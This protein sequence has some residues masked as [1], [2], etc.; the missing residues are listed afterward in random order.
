[1]QPVATK[2]E[3]VDGINDYSLRI[4]QMPGLRSFGALHPDTPPEEMTRQIDFL[5]THG[6]AG[7]KLHPDYQHF[8]PHEDRLESMYSALVQA[9]LAILFHMGIDLGL[10]P[11]LMAPPAELAQVVKAFPALRIIAAHMGG[12][13]LWEEVEKHLLG[14][15][16]WLDTAYC[17]GHLPAEQF[18]YLVRGHGARRILYASDGPWGD[19]RANLDYIRRSGLEPAEIAG[20]IGENAKV[21]IKD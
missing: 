17:A 7:I 15:P 21:F 19:Q 3:Q 20:I 1:V 5:K 2:P 18:V 16:L 11:P 8:H 10:Y 6:F 14:Q 4:G 13:Q 12:F 9:N